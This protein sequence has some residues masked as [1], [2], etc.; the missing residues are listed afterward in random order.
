MA[1]MSERS[2]ENIALMSEVRGKGR[3]ESVAPWVVALVRRC[4][5][6]GRPRGVV[7]F[8]ARYGSIPLLGRKNEK[9]RALL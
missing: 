4:I 9:S 7:F 8:L 5:G 2:P 3:V 1:L 6:E